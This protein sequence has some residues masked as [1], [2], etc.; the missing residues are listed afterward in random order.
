MSVAEASWF[1]GRA[2]V[3]D[4]SAHADE[5]GMLHAFDFGTLPFVP[6]R[7]FTV[8]GVPAGV[9]R[10]GHGH[11]RGEQ[12]LACVQGQIDVLMHCAGREAQ[13]SLRPG[14][15]ILRVAAGVWCRQTYVEPASVLLVLASEPY[16]PDTYFTDRS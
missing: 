5:R 16:S 13:C 6:A 8:S 3:L 10:G 7:I 14:S 2:C 15:G 4:W 9:V 12:L 1:D 11:H